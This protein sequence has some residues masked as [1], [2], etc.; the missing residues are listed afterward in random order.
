MSFKD[1]IDNKEKNGLIRVQK[2]FVNLRSITMIFLEA[3]G[4]K[5]IIEY[6]AD[7]STILETIL[8]FKLYS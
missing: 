2:D 1:Q 7:L 6:A 4:K 5:A 3:R 8:G